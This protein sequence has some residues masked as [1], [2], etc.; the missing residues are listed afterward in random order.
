MGRVDLEIDRLAIDAL[1]VSCYPRGLVLDL[2]LYLLEIVEFA[3]GL[4]M[5]LSPFI[6]ASN[7]RWSMRNMDLVVSRTVL[8]ITGDVDELEDQ[9]AASDD[10][11]ATREKVPTD[12]V[13]ENGGLSGGLGAYNNL[14][15]SEP[16][17]RTMM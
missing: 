10:A 14:Y 16:C 8:A 5:K 7:T 1:V 6:L 13:L 11:A 9:G 17:A 15:T 3:S 12:D 4:M 2:L